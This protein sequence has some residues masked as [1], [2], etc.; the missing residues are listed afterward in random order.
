MAD[1]PRRIPISGSIIAAFRRHQRGARATYLISE[2]RDSRG[3]RDGA[4]SIVVIPG[5]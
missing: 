2:R 3:A 4:P 5:A 1:R